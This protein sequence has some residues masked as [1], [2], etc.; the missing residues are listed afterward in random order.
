M[1]PKVQEETAVISIYNTTM[2]ELCS[3]LCMTQSVPQRFLDV[4]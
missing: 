3:T 2:G 1:F 4:Q